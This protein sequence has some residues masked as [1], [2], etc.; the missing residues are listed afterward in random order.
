MHALT[1]LWKQRQPFV[2]A[3][4][5]VNGHRMDVDAKS[6]VGT[7][8]VDGTNW[9]VMD[10]YCA[11]CARTDPVGSND[12]EARCEHKRAL[13][14]VLAGIYAYDLAEMDDYSEDVANRYAAIGGVL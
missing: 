6:Q 4:V 10:H 14:G 3:S 9:L 11:Y 2:N 5:S 13:D 12:G 1:E 7:L 8:H